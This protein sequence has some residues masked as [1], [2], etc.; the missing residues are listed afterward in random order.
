[1]DG[2]DIKEAMDRGFSYYE[3]TLKEMRVE[4]EKLRK[5]GVPQYPESLIVSYGERGVLD[6]LKRH[7]SIK[8]AIKEIERYL[9]AKEIYEQHPYTQLR[10][11]IYNMEH[12]LG[13]MIKKLTE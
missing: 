1:M 3:N 5:E 8:E 2:I 11:D 6:F 10:N 9:K 7:T 4:L 12:S 13:N